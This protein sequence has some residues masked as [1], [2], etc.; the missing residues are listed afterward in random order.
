MTNLNRAECGDRRKR[1][2]TSKG[3]WRSRE[4]CVRLKGSEFQMVG[5]AYANA[6]DPV[7]TVWH[8]E[9]LYVRD[10]LSTGVVGQE[11]RRRVYPSAMLYRH[12]NSWTHGLK[13]T[14]STTSSQCNSLHRNWWRSAQSYLRVFKTSRTRYSLSVVFLE[15]PIKRLP[16]SS[17]FGLQQSRGRVS[18]EHRMRRSCHNCMKQHIALT[19][20]TRLSSDSSMCI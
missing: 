13:R 8:G 10:Q 2:K 17:R 12:L 1:G 16:H 20:V 15:T 14:R 9:S 5:P 3:V 4:L 7:R 19:A 18:T 11:Q 6:R